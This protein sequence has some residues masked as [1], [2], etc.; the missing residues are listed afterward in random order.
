MKIQ[1]TKGQ[2]DTINMLVP[3][4]ITVIWIFYCY[5]L[6]YLTSISL[7]IKKQ[8]ST[9]RQPRVKWLN[10]RVY[11]LSA[12]KSEPSREN[13][14]GL[15]LITWIYILSLSFVLY[16]NS[17]PPLSFGLSLNVFQLSWFPDSKGHCISFLVTCLLNS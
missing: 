1:S 2:P 8:S 11:Y 15:Q 3:V 6:S 16:K 10:W 5:F 9:G 13:C 14:V 7:N 12:M 17:P 4:G